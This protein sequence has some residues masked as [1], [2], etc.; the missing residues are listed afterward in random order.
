MDEDDNVADEFRPV[1]L[2]YDFSDREYASPERAVVTAFD[3]M[4]F[5]AYGR[6]EGPQRAREWHDLTDVCLE[7]SESLW[8]GSR[9]VAARML[10]RL[11]RKGDLQ[12]LAIGGLEDDPDAAGL[13]AIPKAAFSVGAVIEYQGATNDGQA[14]NVVALE[15]LELTDDGDHHVRAIYSNPCFF[16]RDIEAIADAD[17]P[18]PLQP[19]PPRLSNGKGGRPAGTNGK[20]IA[21]FTLRLQTLGKDAVFAEKD[22]TLAAWLMEHYEAEGLRRP[23]DVNAKRDAKGVRSELFGEKNGAKPQRE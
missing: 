2:T 5:I 14:Y 12:L 4:R 19:P 17:R 10:E 21:A 13:F 15:S 22:D 8:W 1:L 6:F 3:A 16:A 9:N 18:A 23:N 20:P 11:I 7:S